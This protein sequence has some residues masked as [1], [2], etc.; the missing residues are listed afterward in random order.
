MANHMAKEL[1]IGL[2]ELNMLESFIM[3]K[4]KVQEQKLGQMVKIM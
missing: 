2:M 4:F 3:T 1:I